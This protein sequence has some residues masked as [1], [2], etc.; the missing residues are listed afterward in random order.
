[1]KKLFAP[2]LVILIVS[3]FIHAQQD[4]PPFFETLSLFT[5]EIEIIRSS[6]VIDNQ[7]RTLYMYFESQWRAYPYANDLHDV[8]HA[9]Q[10]DDGTFVV[11]TDFDPDASIDTPWLWNLDPQTGIFTPYLPHCGNR[12]TYSDAYENI[13]WMYYTDPQTEQVYLCNAA[14]EELSPALPDWTNWWGGDSDRLDHQPSAS[15]DGNWVI[16]FGRGGFGTLVAAY[17]VS[18]QQFANLGSAYGSDNARVDSWQ[19]DTTA[20]VYTG[21]MPSEFRRGYSLVDVTRE[22]SLQYITGGNGWEV[23]SQYYDD[24]PRFEEEGY[25][26]SSPDGPQDPSEGPCPLAIIYLDPLDTVQYELGN[27]CFNFRTLN[28]TTR[29]YLEARPDSG[30]LRAVM[31]FNPQTGESEQVLAGEIESLLENISPNGRYMFV[32]MDDDGVLGRENMSNPQFFIY[33]LQTGEPVAQVNVPADQLRQGMNKR[34]VN[35]STFLLQPYSDDSTPHPIR[36]IRLVEGGLIETVIAANEYIPDNSGRWQV[37]ENGRYMAIW[38]NQAQQIGGVL[39]L[40]TGE[41]ITVTQPTDS[42]QYELRFS[43]QYSNDLS[44]RVI[45]AGY[46]PENDPWKLWYILHL[47]E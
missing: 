45:P 8:N 20:V 16:F 4:E 2:F 44:I 33:D 22:D 14:T 6:P 15:P 18:T 23:G 42:A 32:S 24:P 25:A 31:R 1:M 43:I 46:T 13:G 38:M 29:Y 34:W 35:D 10:T 19:T 47:S 27:V 12:V 30:E 3:N 41:H 40:I 39:D 17:H 9:F 26:N 11:Q 5:D 28:Y 36:L 21:D 37:S 7:A